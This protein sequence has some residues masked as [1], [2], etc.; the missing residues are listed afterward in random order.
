M[1]RLTSSALALTSLGV[2]LWSAS[3][4]A[5]PGA[6][7][8]IQIAPGTGGEPLTLT[9]GLVDAN[10]DSGPGNEQPSVTTLLKDGNLY[11]VTAYMS[12]NVDRATDGPWQC[13]CA[14]VMVPPNGDPQLLVNEVKIT[15]VGTANA[16]PGN[17]NRRCNH[18]ALA[19]NG[20]AVFFAYG[21]D[22]NANANVQ[23]Y[24]SVLDHTCAIKQPRLRV[25]DGNNN[26]EGAP[27][28][29]YHGNLP[30]G[31]P[32]NLLTTGYF[33][34]NTATYAVTLN[35][36]RVAGDTSV[37]VRGRKVVVAPGNI[38]RPT[39]VAT[40][41]NRALV[42][43][44]QGNQRPPEDG[45]AC[46]LID[47][48]ANIL[49]GRDDD[50]NGTYDRGR[51]VAASQPGQ[52]IYM[53]QPLAAA[54]GGGR[55]ALM[56]M[57]SDGMGRNGSAQGAQRDPNRQ[58]GITRAGIYTFQVNGTANT[59]QQVGSRLTMMGGFQ[60]HSSICSGD[61]GPNAAELHMMF[62]D[63]SVTGSGIGS[64][65]PLWLDRLTNTWTQIDAEKK[66]IGSENADS[67]LLANL[68]GRNPGQQG[69]DFL[70][71]LGSVRNPG[72]RLTGN[73]RPDVDSFFLAPYAGR[74]FGSS[75]EP[76]NA[77]FMT[78][79]PAQYNDWA[80]AASSSAPGSS[81]AP[82]SSGPAPSSQG[83]SSGGGGGSVIPI[84]REGGDCFPNNSCYQGLVCTAGT[85]ERGS[86]TSSSG[87]AVASSSAAGG[88]SAAAGNSSAAGSPSS[89]GATATSGTTTTDPGDD[90][91]QACACA[92]V[93]GSGGL[94][95]AA[96]L[97]LVAGLALRRRRR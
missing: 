4:A 11:I 53:N 46:A 15:G 34:Q 26:N 12:S 67:G 90:T 5:A 35:V 57:Q 91:A 49:D 89:G 85:C 28:L 2:A 54:L 70:R 25:S 3:A 80:P 36:Q 56:V 32:S 68:L 47:E 6:P 60:S 73:F 42:C 16:G 62:M 82:S 64:L 21:S 13:K 81:A 71:C 18:P 45:V 61:Y 52:N 7:F 33:R 94:T 78:M 83:G 77:L 87:P 76:K 27:D 44:A 17:G 14:S 37:S 55:V 74:K 50:N 39:I 84:G 65:T 9:S 96:G 20:E 95:R 41:Y 31:S 51:I 86:S 30:D 22:D 69:R 58:R 79:I 72:A 63:A 40:A 92:V 19:T 10:Q 29:V 1:S 23:T 24:V 93:D 59:F 8:E 43:A 66:A 75:T 48:D 88:S 38:G 97:L